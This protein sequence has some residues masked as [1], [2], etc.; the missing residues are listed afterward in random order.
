MASRPRDGW[1][2]WLVLFAAA[3]AIAVFLFSHPAEAR[4]QSQ[5]HWGGSDFAI[6]CTTVREWRGAVG[7][8]SASRKSDLARQFNITRKQRRQAYACLKGK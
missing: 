6:S 3:C 8:M 7:R 4:S 5:Q 2:I 1:V